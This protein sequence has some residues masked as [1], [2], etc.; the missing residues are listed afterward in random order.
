M[1]LIK[2]GLGALGGT[3]AD[4]WKEFFYCDAIDKEVLVVKGQKRVSGRS[5]NTKGSDNIITN[6]SGIAVADGQC[7]IIVDQ[8]KVVEVCA[9]P[10]EFTYDSSTE[11]SIF[12]GSLGESI[13][14]TF[15]TI[16]KRFT[17]GG[18]TGKDQR[19][20]YFN[21]KEIIDNK[22]G[23]RNP[24]P[25]RVVDSKIGLDIDVEL[26][27][28]GVY[29]YKIAD[30]LL[31]YA[32]VCGNVDG[33]YRR[34]E[35][36][37]QLKNEF[38]SAL[39]PSLGR[40]SA[41]EIRPNQLMAHTMELEDAMNSTLS[42]KWGAAR[43]LKI[44]SVALSSVSLTE[45]DTELIKNAQK[46]AILRDPG[47]AAATL[48]AAQS[49]AM[50]T[51]AGNPNGAMMGFMGMNMAN[52]NGG[53][54]A[55][56]LYTM[57]E[58]QREQQRAEA[59]QKQASQPTNQ[60]VGGD[61]WVCECGAT[62]NGKFCPECGKKRPEPP[63]ADSW[64]C[65]C[66]AVNTGKFCSECGSPKPADDGWVCSCGTKNKGKF[67]SECGKKKPAGEPLYRCDKC[68]WEPEDPKHPPKFC[69]ECGDK[70][71]DDDINS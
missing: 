22:F 23:T 26:R 57:A 32:N 45:E 65:A 5:S 11:P 15:K 47:M 19:V 14:E 35:I 48:T 66:G 17:Y 56:G 55:Q 50:K 49:E 9:E 69:P 24:V 42:E 4:Q 61:S 46:T 28:S 34:E 2:A 8:G 10:G 52:G 40:L 51:A 70:F 59:E 71:S 25:F 29:S 64:V 63:K 20:Y 33:E 16:G 54:N 12:S 43:G 3:L 18:D 60:A 58:Q 62:V 7:M 6:G 31:F 13:I 41:L 21:T 68:G 36:D 27:C 30:P 53:L 39:N 67:C 38:I 37:P 44:V 1:G